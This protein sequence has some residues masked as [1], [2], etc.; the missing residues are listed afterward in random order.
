MITI[1]KIS[2]SGNDALDTFSSLVGMQFESLERLSGLTFDA[3]RTAMA[4]SFKHLTSLSSIKDPKE[5]ASLNAG[6][7]EPTMTNSVGYVRSCYGI[8]TDLG[9]S[10]GEMMSAKYD[11]ATKELDVALEK[12]SKSAPIGGDA[13]V[14]AVKTAMNASAKAVDE[15]AKVARESV[16]LAEANM[17]KASDAAI[18]ATAKATKSLG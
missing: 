9:E 11:A 5:A 10:M 4:D 2:A 13:L 8:A 12:F 15:A 7:L 16:S 1:D 18:K 14:T 17:M 6:L 3:S